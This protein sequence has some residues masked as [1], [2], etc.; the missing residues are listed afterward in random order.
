MT[1]QNIETLKDVKCKTGI[2]Q[3]KNHK[4]YTSGTHNVISQWVNDLP[5]CHPDKNRNSEL[6]IDMN[7]VNKLKN[8]LLKKPKP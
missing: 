4:E 3:L 2:E 1:L 5:F 7:K 8:E 6:K